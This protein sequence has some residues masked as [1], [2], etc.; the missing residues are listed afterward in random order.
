VSDGVKLLNEATVNLRA[1]H[2][3]Y[4]LRCKTQTHSP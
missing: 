2:R 1:V 4:L 3:P